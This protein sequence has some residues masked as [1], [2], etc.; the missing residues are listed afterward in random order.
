MTGQ[1]PKKAKAKGKASDSERIR[2]SKRNNDT[3]KS[4]PGPSQVDLV[5]VQDT[6]K[7]LIREAY[8]ALNDKRC[9]N[10][11]GIFSKLLNILEERD[12]QSLHLT[13]LDYL[14]LQYGH[15]N[16]LLGIG[17]CVELA[18]AENKL[19]EIIQLHS[20]ER[21]NCLAFYGIGNVY[22]K[23]NRL[24]HVTND[25]SIVIPLYELIHVGMIYC[26]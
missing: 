6:V 1:Q 19:K 3:P 8:E 7:S 24:N 26:C 12:L 9:R 20:K 18:K 5:T 10:A 4:P 23:Q 17:Q 14:V 2:F 13:K 11:E 15:A 16:A 22:F 25:S 21:F